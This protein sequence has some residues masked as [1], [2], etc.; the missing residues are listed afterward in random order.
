MVRFPFDDYEE[1]LLSVSKFCV[2]ACMNCKD[3]RKCF[4][5]ILIL[6]FVNK[7]EKPSSWSFSA[8]I[9]VEG[10]YIENFIGFRCE[11]Q[12][13]T[14]LEHQRKCGM[15]WGSELFPPH[16]MPSSHEGY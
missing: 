2:L 9:D 7:Q 13:E 3:Y 4:K 5:P 12:R 16:P 15:V 1:N 10:G 8:V 11:V 14:W 6:C